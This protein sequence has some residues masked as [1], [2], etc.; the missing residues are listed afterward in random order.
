MEHDIRLKIIDLNLGFKILKKFE[1]NWIYIKMVSHT[2]KNSSNCA[3]FKF[4][5]KDL[6]LL[7]DDIFL[8][9]NEDEDRLYL[10]K[11]GIV[12]TEC[13]PEE[14]EILFIIAS[15]D[16]IIEVFIKKYLPVLNVRLDELTNPSKNII[17]TEGQ[18]DWRHLK[19]ALKKLNGNDMFESLDIEFFEPDKKTQMGNDKLKKIRDYHALLENEYC[20]IFIFDRDADDINSE[21]GDAEVLYHGNNVYSMLLPVPE[22]RKDTPYISIEHYYFDKDLFREDIN[23]RRLYMVK[24]FDKITKKH[25]LIP[26]LYALK[27]NKESSDIGILDFK[28]MKYEEQEEDLSK[29]AKDGQ[30]IAL[31][32]SNFI[33]HIENEEFKGV[34]VAAFSSVFTMIED[35]LQDYLQNKAGEI[36][37]SKGVYLKKYPTGLSTLSLFAEAPKELLTLYKGTNLVTVGPVV[38]ENH[39]KLILEIKAL[40]NEEWHQIIQFPL[41]ITPYL[42]DF[43]MKKNKNRY[44]RIELHLFSPDRAISSSREILKDDIS[45]TILLRA[46]NL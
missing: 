5:L 1:D 31:S 7:D 18:T 30:N 46:L 16:G 9:G 27:I 24:E 15:S 35:I 3:Y 6:M 8:Y 10:N 38:L 14:D 45:G 20:K 41:D 19:Y 25:L 13:S 43:I 22:H 40:I 21:F 34:N 12:Q 33:K 42:V 4:K 44:N 26:N 29:V 23:G 17:I 32:K 2:S 36:E 11:S 37:I 39:N 28:I